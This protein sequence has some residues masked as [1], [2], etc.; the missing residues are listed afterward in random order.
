MRLDRAFTN[1]D[2]LRAH[3][4]NLL[5]FPGTNLRVASVDF[6]NGTTKVDVRWVRKREANR[7]ST[8]HVTSESN[9]T[10]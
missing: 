9:Q 3:V 1:E 10:P 2:E 6:V 8:S 7:I 4:E 5:G